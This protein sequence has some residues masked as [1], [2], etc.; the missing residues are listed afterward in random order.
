M[1][2]WKRN[3]GRIQDLIDVTKR[4][5]RQVLVLIYGN[6]EQLSWVENVAPQFLSEIKNSSWRSIKLCVN[7]RTYPPPSNDRRKYRKKA[8]ETEPA[9]VLYL[10]TRGELNLNDGEQISSIDL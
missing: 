1:L 8:Q 3:P 7:Q 9:L 2:V 10:H 4:D 6:L 5:L